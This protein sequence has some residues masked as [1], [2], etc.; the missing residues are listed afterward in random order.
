MD[1]YILDI[2]KESKSSIRSPKPKSSY[3]AISTKLCP[4]SSWSSFS[5]KIKQCNKTDYPQQ[6][7][8]A[9]RELS[10]ESVITQTVPLECTHQ[11]LS[12]SGHT[13]RFRLQENE[14]SSLYC[15]LIG[16]IS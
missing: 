10:F 11:E 3:G 7:T 1:K 14:L 9:H 2:E 8:S 15:N 13:F 12:F 5:A 6:G 16:T 4:S